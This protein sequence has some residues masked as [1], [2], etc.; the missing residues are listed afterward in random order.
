MGQRS[1]IYARITDEDGNKRLI[2]RYYQWNFAERMVARAKYSIE[3]LEERRNEEYLRVTSNEAI[4]RILDANFSMIDCVIS[5]NIIDE[6]NEDILRDGLV[7]NFNEGVFETQANNDG[8]LFIDV[9]PDGIKYAF[10]D[11]DCNVLDDAYDYVSWDYNCTL[12]ERLQEGNLADEDLKK[13]TDNAKALRNYKCLTQEEV[14]DFIHDEYSEAADRKAIEK[15]W[16]KDGIYEY[17]IFQTAE[18]EKMIRITHYYWIHDE[19]ENMSSSEM[20]YNFK[21][22]IGDYLSNSTKYQFLCDGAK[23][24]YS[25]ITTDEM[26]SFFLKKNKIMTDYPNYNTPLG[27]YVGKLKWHVD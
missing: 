1:Q 27:T 9:T 8:K 6:V 18:L 10:T 7:D 12:E 20:Y 24:D 11:C 16:E 22:S 15:V 21:V 14:D 25:E 2:A 17:E 19:E 26:F 4:T 3:W 5:T 13:F 23:R